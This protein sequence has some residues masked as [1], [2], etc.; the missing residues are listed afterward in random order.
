[1]VGPLRGPGQHYLDISR[2]REQPGPGSGTPSGDAATGGE[3][4]E[5]DRAGARLLHGKR[6]H[7]GKAEPGYGGG[8]SGGLSPS[9]GAVP[10]SGVAAGGADSTAVGSTTVVGPT[11]PALSPS[12]RLGL[13]GAWR[14]Q[15]QAS[16]SSLKLPSL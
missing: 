13:T 8:T 11:P 4:R 1:M 10:G 2:W 3:D 7:W 6:R 16:T 5:D 14:G 9:G 12:G 15:G